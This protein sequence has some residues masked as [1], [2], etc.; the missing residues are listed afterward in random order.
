[1]TPPSPN[2]YQNYLAEITR[3]LDQGR[4]LP[5]GGLPPLPRPALKADAP[6]ALIFAPHPDDEMIIG[7]LPLRLFREAGLEVIN[8]AVTQG[9]N[10]SRQPERF[11][12]LKAACDYIGFGLVQ[13][14][15]NGLQK[16]NLTAR[17]QDPALWAESVKAIDGILREHRPAFIF[18]PHDRDWNSTHIG[19]HYLV[20]EAL[21]NMDPAFSCHAIET[22]FW[23]QM[24]TP[25]LMVESSPEQ[26]ADLIAATSFHAGEVRRNPYHLIMPGWMQ[27]NVRRGSE[28]VGGQGGKA[29]EFKFATLY[30]A[31]KWV[32]GKM[33][34]SWTSGKVL[35]TQQNALDLFH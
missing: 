26:V 15:P 8:V 17:D 12:E 3:L 33:Q 22:E 21:E 18:F 20:I 31:R 13:T 10:K 23:G 32:E 16:V 1:M 7:A 30:R 24:D 28:L 27:D 9:S 34:N 5:L 14:A 35:S 29:P 11:Q 4:N 2:P 6:K 19:T 25:N